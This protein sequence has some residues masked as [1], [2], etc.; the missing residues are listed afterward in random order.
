MTNRTNPRR[1][2]IC[3]FG[4][5]V[6]LIILSVGYFGPQIRYYLT[7]RA[8]L[9][10]KPSFPR[11]W[12]AVP[13]PLADPN[14]S[15][16]GG[17]TL[18]SY[19]YTFQVPWNQVAQIRD[20]GDSVETEFKTGQIVRF[21]NPG[22]LR[23]NFRRFQQILSIAPSQ[24][25][26][27]CSHAKFASDLELLNAKGSLFE[28]NPVAPE[29]FSFETSQYRGFEIRYLGGRVNSASVYLFDGD[30]HEF[31][32]VL[33]IVR[34]ANAQLGQLDINRVIQTFADTK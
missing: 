23:M 22:L 24:I 16:I 30:D 32:L 20:T 21:V 26:P 28:H 15:N 3:V 8:R 10:Q 13:Q 33:S 11:G 5:G 14:S 1:V 17:M 12:D 34:D 7:V 6:L 18:S 25:S 9:T 4:A 31:A 29:I 19:G 2:W 27:F